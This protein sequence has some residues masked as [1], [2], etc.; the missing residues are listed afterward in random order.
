MYDAE[1][2]NI[3]DVYRSTTVEKDSVGKVKVTSTE[4]N[5]TFCTQN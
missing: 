1:T 2:I 3:Q 4:M 5:L